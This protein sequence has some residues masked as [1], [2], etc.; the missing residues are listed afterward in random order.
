MPSLLLVIVIQCVHRPAL[1]GGV[2]LQGVGSFLQ[3]G[4]NCKRQAKAFPTKFLCVAGSTTTNLPSVF[5]LTFEAGNSANYN[6]YFS[7]HTQFTNNVVS[8]PQIASELYSSGMI[9]MYT[10]NYSN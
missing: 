1:K 8:D 3:L 2:F 10:L 7:G 4:S 5:E 6:Q 9:P